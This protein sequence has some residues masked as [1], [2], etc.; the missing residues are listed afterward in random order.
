MGR[1]P[2]SRQRRV[3][4]AG[5]HMDLLM[6]VLVVIVHDPFTGERVVLFKWLV[7]PK[8]VSIDS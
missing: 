8:A 3:A 5:V 7:R 1:E 4:L 6:N 2:P